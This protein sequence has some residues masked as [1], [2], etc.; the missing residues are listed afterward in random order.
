MCF[1]LKPYNVLVCLPALTFLHK[2]SYRNNGVATVDT[3]LVYLAA[4]L[5][6]I[7]Y[8]NANTAE[9]HVSFCH[10]MCGKGCKMEH[11]QYINGIMW[12]FPISFTLILV[13]YLVN[14]HI[15]ELAF[16]CSQTLFSLLPF[17]LDKC[18]NI[19]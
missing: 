1:L 17:I 11:V 16:F 13:C 14:F 2:I 19:L 7:R 8:W 10:S 6:L 3:A 18:L 5:L 4:M 12:W 15:V 9:Y